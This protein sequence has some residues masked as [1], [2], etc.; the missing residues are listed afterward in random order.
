MINW[1][2]VPVNSVLPFTFDSFDGGTGASITL[3][4]LALG[5]I[6]L[7][8]GVSM[9]QRSSTAGFVLT[10]TDGIDLDTITGIHGFSIDTSD[11][12]DAGFYAVGSFFTV[13]VSAVTID[14]QTVNFVAGTFRLVAAEAIAGKPKADVDAWLGTAAA[15]PTVAGVPEVD[16][17]HVAG[18]T[19]DVSALATNVAAI[20]VDTGTTLDDL[21]DTEVAT[22]ITTLGT[23]AGVSLAAD[24]A[25][26]EAQTDDIG[27]AGAGLT[28]IPWNA[29]W[30]AEVQSEATDALVAFFT[31]A[32]ALVDL[33]WDEPLAD[34]VA[35]GSFGQRNAAIRTG[36]AAGGAAGSI[37][38]DGSA[39]ATD[40]FYN[41][42]MLVI[43]GGTGAN[44]CRIIEDYT[45]ATKVGTVSPNWVTTPDA[46]SIFVILP[47]DDIPGAS[48]PSA[49]T[50]ATAVVEKTLTEGY[51]ADAVAPTL[52]QALFMVHQMLTHMTVSGTT[53]T[54]YKLDGVTV[55]ATFTLTLDSD[56]LPTAL[57]RTS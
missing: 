18:A 24:I 2:S 29:A 4:G 22:I 25:A 9:T 55:A 28:A 21:I 26:I 33:V 34:H 40:D 37:T 16:V 54:V 50:I 23:P 10:D 27:A 12:T 47:F 36:T 56:N 11:N 35:V 43:T 13:V 32:A 7:Y 8:K 51:A 48:A 3:T 41:N 5:D 31:S 30:D 42:T 14:A 20:L 15:T 6:L 57:T 53:L 17:T 1:G 19:T 52:Q 46:T 38:L 39:S 45:G 44:Q 49:A